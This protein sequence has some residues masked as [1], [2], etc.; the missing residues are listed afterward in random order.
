MLM[1]LV[2]THLVV[3]KSEAVIY[4]VESDR[5][6]LSL[7][8]SDIDMNTESLKVWDPWFRNMLENEDDGERQTRR[9]TVSG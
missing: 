6:C 8:F 4:F 3:Q 1:T 2:A 5:N 9:L 7:I